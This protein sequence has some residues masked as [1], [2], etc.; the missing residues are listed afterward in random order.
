MNVLTLQKTLKVMFV[1]V[2]KWKFT[3]PVSILQWI[4]LGGFMKR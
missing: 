2:R 4:I 3:I 1:K